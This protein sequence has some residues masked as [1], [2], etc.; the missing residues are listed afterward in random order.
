LN[1]DTL[2]VDDPD[3]AKAEPA[4]LVE[5]GFDDLGDQLRRDAVQVELFGDGEL[6]LTCEGVLVGIVV[7]SR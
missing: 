2:S 6:G 5:V 7:R 3:V 1:A 4:R